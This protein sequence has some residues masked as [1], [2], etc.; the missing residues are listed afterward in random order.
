MMRRWRSCCGTCRQEP[1]RYLARHRTRRLSLVE[2]SASRRAPAQAMPVPDIDVDD[3][4][5]RYALRF[6]ATTAEEVAAAAAADA[7]AAT[8]EVPA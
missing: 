1:A 6:V 8:A 4:G 5:T 3:N 2:D 7:A